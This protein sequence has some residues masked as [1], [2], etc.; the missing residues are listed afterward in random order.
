MS[1]MA[2]IQNLLAGKLRELSGKDISFTKIEI[3]PNSFQPKAYVVVD[4][5]LTKVTYSPEHLQDIFYVAHFDT[6]KPYGEAPD[7]V[8]PKFDPIEEYA[9]ILWT[10][11]QKELNQ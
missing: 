5:V 7:H 9:N 10:E 8:S 1:A 11:I 4:G 3:D 2:E 6:V